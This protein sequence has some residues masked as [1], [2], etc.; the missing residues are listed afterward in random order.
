[1]QDREGALLPTTHAAAPATDLLQQQDHRLVAAQKREKSHLLLIKATSPC[2]P[3]QR[4]L[5][6]LWHSVNKQ[7]RH[8]L[9]YL[10][11]SHHRHSFS[12]GSSASP[13]VLRIKTMAWRVLRLW[14]GRQFQVEHVSLTVLVGSV[15]IH[16]FPSVHTMWVGL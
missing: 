16:A 13:T 7:L 10:R 6:C 12:G 3:N 8:L 4:L 14:Q 9:H 5:C 15:D 11:N 2:H 1:M